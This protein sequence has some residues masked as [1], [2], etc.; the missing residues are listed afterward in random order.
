MS[1]YVCINIHTVLPGPPSIL[2]VSRFSYSLSLQIRLS[3][4][5]TAPLLLVKMN[6]TLGTRLINTTEWSGSFIQGKVL[7]PVLVSSLQPD[8][9]YTFKVVAVN[10][11]GPGS[12]SMKF[13]FTTG[14][15]MYNIIYTNRYYMYVYT[16]GK[17]ITSIS[18]LKILHMA[19]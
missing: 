19:W 15:C 2:L 3:D 16:M 8:T 1:S 12:L 7:D 18:S 10:S 14:I 5:G 13:I 9:N 4:I 17:P 11:L 6:V